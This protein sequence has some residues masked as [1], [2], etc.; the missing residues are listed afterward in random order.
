MT[1]QILHGLFYHLLFGMDMIAPL[2]STDLHHWCDW[3]VSEG[4]GKPVVLFP[5]KGCP[6][7]G[8]RKLLELSGESLNSG[9]R[10]CTLPSQGL[11]HQWSCELGTLRRENPGSKVRALSGGGTHNGA[12]SRAGISVSRPIKGNYQGYKMPEGSQQYSVVF[13]AW[14]NETI[15]RTNTCQR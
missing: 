15:R 10:L 7:R 13:R 11:A 5:N 2:R 9:V 6:I 8:T 4:I 14:Q 1:V 3:F 12:S